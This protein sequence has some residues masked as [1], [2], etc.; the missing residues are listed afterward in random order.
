MK[1][2]GIFVN[3]VKTFVITCESY[4]DAAHFVRCHNA[5]IIPKNVRIIQLFN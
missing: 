4:H 3:G 5:G 2:Y 1:K